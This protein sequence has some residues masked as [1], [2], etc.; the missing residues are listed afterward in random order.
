MYVAFQDLLLRQEKE[1]TCQNTSRVPCPSSLL[2]AASMIRD[3]M[4]AADAKR[5]QSLF[6]QVEKCHKNEKGGG[7]DGR[8][9][10]SGA[11]QCQKDKEGWCENDLHF[12]DE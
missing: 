6:E 12:R 8:W 3:I 9:T 4:D 5:K 11:A 1:S 2:A 7:M 10:T